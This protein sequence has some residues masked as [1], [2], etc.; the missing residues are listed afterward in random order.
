M[1]CKVADAQNKVTSNVK[2]FEPSGALL[3]NPWGGNE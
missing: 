2:D 3:I 1:E